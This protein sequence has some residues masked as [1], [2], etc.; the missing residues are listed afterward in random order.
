WHINLVAL[1][2]VVDVESGRGCGEP[3]KEALEELMGAVELFRA[4]FGALF[5]RGAE[6]V[7]L[8]T[9]QGRLLDGDT[10]LHALVD[11]WCRTRTSVHG[12]IAVPLT[13]ALAV[14][15]IAEKH[16]R[17]VIRPGRSRRALAQ[18]VLDGRA[19]FAGSTVGGFIFG[20]FFPAF[21]G[22]LSVGMLARMMAAEMTT[23]DQVV[24]D[25]P[26]FHKEHIAVFCPTDRKGVVMRAVTDAA[27]GLSPDLEEGVRVRYDDGWALVLP[28]A[29]DPVVNV[30]AEADG[31]DA[32]R[33]RAREWARV[34]EEVVA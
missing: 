27:S 26:A 4:D 1:N 28:D 17:E 10:A 11:L 23:L 30:W 2:A 25:L 19:A 18:A 33:E 22:V 20:D 21:D 9:P 29:G 7:R 32:A 13:A 31:V 15:R 16:G 24:D 3:T 5:D 14:D 34:V 8:M 12:A 6:R